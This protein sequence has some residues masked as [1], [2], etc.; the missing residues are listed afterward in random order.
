MHTKFN[1]DTFSHSKVV[2][3]GGVGG[4]G[5]VETQHC[6]LIS[7]LLFFK[8]KESRLKIINVLKQYFILKCA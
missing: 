3:A 1:K 8:N 5:F 2:R 4:G 6:D 7:I